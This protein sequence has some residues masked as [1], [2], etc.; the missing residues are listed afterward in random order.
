M[1]VTV[2]Q[3]RVLLVILAMAL[4]VALLVAIMQ[5]AEV[6]KTIAKPP[7]IVISHQKNKPSEL[8][9]N[10]EHSGLDKPVKI[11]SATAAEIATRL[12]GIGEAIAQRIVSKRQKQGP[13]QNF[14]QLKTVSGVGAA[15]IEANKQRI[16]FD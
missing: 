13:F 9:T 14:E 7:P 2:N 1:K 10:L 5:S 11:N 15:K 12:E 3:R 16:S 8:K 4:I 6:E